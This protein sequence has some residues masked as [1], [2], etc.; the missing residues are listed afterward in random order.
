[1]FVDMCCLADNWIT[2]AWQ[3]RSNLIFEFSENTVIKTLYYSFQ[4]TDDYPGY[5]LYIPPKKQKNKNKQKSTVRIK[6]IN[7]SLRSA[8][9]MLPNSDLDHLIWCEAE[10][11]RLLIDTDVLTIHAHRC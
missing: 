8:L 4:R 2:C 1:M 11:H 3:I 7:L 5:I 9:T 6:S 10:I